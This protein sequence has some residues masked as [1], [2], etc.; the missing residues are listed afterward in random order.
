MPATAAAQCSPQCIKRVQVRAFAE[1]HGGC[2]DRACVTRVRAKAEHRH[3]RAVVA[4]YRAFFENVARCESGGDWQINTGNGY[5]GGVQ[6]ALTSWQAV[7]GRGYPH[8][9]SKLEQLYRA[10]RLLKIQGRGAWPVCG[11]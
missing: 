5:F 11:R 2:R 1:R 6:F 9:A 3:K 8:Q 4:P 10:V 7:G